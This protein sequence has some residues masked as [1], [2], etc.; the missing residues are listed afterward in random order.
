MVTSIDAEKEDFLKFIY[1]HV[2]TL[3]GSFLPNKFK[4]QNLFMT[5][6]FPEIMSLA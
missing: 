5:K 2:H 6:K 1:S 3:F 4:V